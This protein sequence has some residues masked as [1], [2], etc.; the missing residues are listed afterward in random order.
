[1]LGKMTGDVLVH[2]HQCGMLT[3]AATA[4][5]LK[6]KRGNFKI[7]FRALV[8]DL[9]DLHEPVAG[10]APGAIRLRLLAEHACE[11]RSSGLDR[12]RLRDD[13]ARPVGCILRAGRNGS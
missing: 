12:L 1:M 9:L 11:V 4:Q 5:R 13:G 2:P 10:R 8:G 6:Y 7:T 3:S